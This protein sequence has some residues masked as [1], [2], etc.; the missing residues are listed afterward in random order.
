M[1]TIII[2]KVNDPSSQNPKSNIIIQ[3]DQPT[4]SQLKVYPSLW[5]QTNYQGDPNAFTINLITEGEIV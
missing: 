1:I 3:A 5:I 2:P 4:E